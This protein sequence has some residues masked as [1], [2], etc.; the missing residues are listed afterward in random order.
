MDRYECARDPRQKVSE[1]YQEIQQ[2]QT[3]DQPIETV[4]M[5]YRI[6]TV[7]LLPKDNKSKATSSFFLIKMIAK[8]EKKYILHTKTKTNKEPAQ[9]MVGI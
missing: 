7:T 6:F 8:P 5:S 9:T 2:S 3:A 1:Y 4:R